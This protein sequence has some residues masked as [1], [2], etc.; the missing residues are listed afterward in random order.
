[1]KLKPPLKLWDMAIITFA[2]TLTGFSAYRVYLTPRNTARVLIEGAGRRWIFPLES[3]ET[4]AVP[5]PL[6]NT[7][8]RIH[9]NQAW[10]ESSPCNNKV[11]IAAGH[12][13]RHGEFAACL[14]NFVLVMIE[15]H[16]DL[17]PDTP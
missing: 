15:G 14:P 3:E 8:I 6:G 13:R 2:L 16:D 5:G 11:C 17:N 7:I 12:L 4:V 10:V 9:D 1:M